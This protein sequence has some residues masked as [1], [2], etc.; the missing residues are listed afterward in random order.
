MPKIRCPQLI[1]SPA[2]KKN[3]TAN[4]NEVNTQ[5]GFFIF[6]YSK[7]RN[8]LTTLHKNKNS[9]VRFSTKPSSST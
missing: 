8:K 5:S 1:S 9:A 7:K 3:R 2:A 4:A 6:R